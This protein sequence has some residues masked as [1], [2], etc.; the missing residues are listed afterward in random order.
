MFGE[1]DKISLR[2]SK[3]VMAAELYGKAVIFLP[4]V[5]RECTVAGGGGSLLLGSVLVLGLI[6]LSMG[7]ITKK[8]KS[9]WILTG[10]FIYF[11]ADGICILWMMLKLVRICFLPE[12]SAAALLVILFLTCFWTIRGSIQK[13]IRTGEMIYVICLA[14]F[15]ALTVAA[16]RTIHLSWIFPAVGEQKTESVGT[17]LISA[18]GVL[19]VCGNVM[20]IIFLN[21]YMEQKNGDRS[22]ELV[23][24]AAKEAILGFTV[25][26]IIMLGN[27]GKN[28]MKDLDLP[29]VESMINAQIP[30]KFLQ[31]WDSVYAMFLL[32]ILLVAFSGSLFYLRECVKQ[33][34]AFRSVEGLENRTVE[35]VS[36]IFFAAA[37]LY[38]NIKHELEERSYPQAVE[39][40]MKDGKLYGG[41]GE[42]MVEAE[43][44]QELCEKS[45]NIENKY[46]DTGHVKVLLLEREMFQDKNL[47]L[48]LFR[49]IRKSRVLDTNVMIL[50]YTDLQGESI[51]REMKKKTGEEAG[52]YLADYYE[53]H[54]SETSPLTIG[55][56]TEKI[57]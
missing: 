38:G 48:S 39:V 23:W 25:S 57:L 12:K 8:K 56:Y 22:A 10:I 49:E 26:W 19:L 5:F 37:L 43:T 27:L 44:F 15:A 13:R 32:L 36:L 11:L 46:L 45:R 34:G 52:K 17:I 31:R 4:L 20:G 40:S 9:K 42:H 50:K 53:N 2:Q 18:V 54:S 21:P 41:F 16:A 24:T 47:I 28:N 14:V 1:N 35:I 33:M 30:G 3:R 51:I 7:F 29:V 6:K 55:E